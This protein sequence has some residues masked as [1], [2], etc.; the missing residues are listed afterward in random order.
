MN[1]ALI[2]GKSQV[3]DVLIQGAKSGKIPHAQLFLGKEG[4]GGLAMAIA[5]ASY[6]LCTDKKEDDSCGECKA[7]TKSIKL[8]HP[9]L[10]LS[11]PVVKS[12]DKKREET[13]S[14][15]FLLQ[16]RPL[17][18]ENPFLSFNQWVETITTTTARPNINVKET[19]DISIKLGMQSFESDYKILIMW[20]PEYLGKEGN[21][22]LKLI[23]EPPENT[24][25]ILVAEDSD[26]ILPT[27]L[28]RCQIT[29]IP[30]FTNEEILSVLKTKTEEDKDIESIVNLASGNMAKALQLL[31][32]ED[33]KY[34]ELLMQ[35][36]R[37]AYKSH[38]EEITNFAN[39]ISKWNQ[40][41]QKTFLEYALHF[42]RAYLFWYFTQ[43][44]TSDIS[45]KEKDIAFRMKA[46]L[47]FEKAEKLEEVID[48]S[49]THIYRN[50]NSKILFT[51]IT[52]D[53]GEIM[54]N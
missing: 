50:A 36:L 46:F 21:R 40:E 30:K 18:I 43:Q 51:S 31:D 29:K 42:L 2:P 6:L 48:E 7:C 12:S 41:Q 25:I 35:W 26:M 9:D 4:A 38:P 45:E 32:A 37:I 52:L 16:F 47:N 44:W 13:T 1:F 11:F 8:V 53:I 23:E 5:Y 24:I 3:K 10:H 14:A 28:S 15:D 33:K 49:I 20:M 54:K 19:N 39:D 27:V 17:F 22:I 34:N